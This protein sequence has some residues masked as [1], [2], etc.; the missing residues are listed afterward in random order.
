MMPAERACR[1]RLASHQ[2]I[3]VGET[4]G[5]TSARAASAIVVQ[6]N[7]AYS[8]YEVEAKVH[9]SVISQLIK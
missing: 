7:G 9:L 1:M 6:R 5:L 3:E 2:R 8:L 4:S